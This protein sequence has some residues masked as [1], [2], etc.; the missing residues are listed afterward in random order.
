MILAADI[1]NAYITLGCIGSR[2]VYFTSRFATLVQKTEDEYAVDFYRVLELN[3]VSAAGIEGAVISS[4]V[5]PADFA[6]TRALEKVTGHR[7]LV[8]GPG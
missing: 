8:V 2:G 6:V 7:P 5:P 1:S 3:G 4:V